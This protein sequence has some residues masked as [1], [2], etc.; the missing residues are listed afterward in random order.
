MR[1]ITINGARFTLT[2]IIEM[3]GI[4]PLVLIISA[5][6]LAVVALILAVFLGMWTYNDAKERTDDPILWTLIVL[7]VPMP[8]GLIIYLL[9]GRKEVTNQSRNRYLTPLIITAVFFMI[10]LSVVIGSAI[11]FIILLAEQGMLNSMWWV[12]W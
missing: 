2:E 12:L 8:I 1:I 11:Y 6:L 4:T 7:F 10:K 3:F 5:L 9:A